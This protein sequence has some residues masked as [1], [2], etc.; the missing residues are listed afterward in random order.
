M[1]FARNHEAAS[2]RLRSNSR[3]YVDLSEGVGISTRLMDDEEL[4]SRN[5]DRPPMGQ[6]PPLPPSTK[7]PR[8][9]L[10]DYCTNEWER[11]DRWKSQQNKSH[12]RRMGSDDSF[13]DRC[14]AL[15]KAPKVRRYLIL[16]TLVLVI[17]VWLW[18]SAIWPVW[19]EHRALSR[20]ISERSRVQSGGLF[21]TN[22]RPSFPI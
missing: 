9:P 6:L 12:S 5:P 3:P 14:I 13:S 18:S 7:V 22:V 8:K 15:I 4:L 2:P 20:S 21:G 16:Y 11:D 17:S 1:S 10:I 19:S